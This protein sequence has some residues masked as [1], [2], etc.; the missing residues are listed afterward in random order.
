MDS[1]LSARA[2]RRPL[3]PILNYT[4][5]CDSGFIVREIRPLRVFK[6]KEFVRFT[7]R[8]KIADTVLC[9]AVARAERG[10]IDAD[11]GGGLIKQRVARPGQGRSGGFRTLLV[12]RAATRIVFV[13]GFAKSE[14]ANITPDRLL[15]WRRIAA[16]YLAMT[17]VSIDA[18]IADGEL[19]EVVCN[20]KTNDKIP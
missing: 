12:Y 5:E 7:R 1:V 4:T 8:E 14:R 13:Y 18:V 11:L 9:D 6:S 19:E 16:V 10:T 17:E 3:T 20:G 15:F 2:E